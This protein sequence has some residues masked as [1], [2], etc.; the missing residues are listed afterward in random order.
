VSDATETTT[1]AAESHRER[2]LEA[3][4]AATKLRRA[5]ALVA[6]VD[7]VRARGEP[8]APHAA[9]LRELADLQERLDG[10]LADANQLQKEITAAVV[11]GMFYYLLTL[12]ILIS[13]SGFLIISYPEM[14]IYFIIA[15]GVLFVGFLAFYLLRM[16]HFRRTTGR[17]QE[18]LREVAESSADL[19]ETIGEREAALR[20]NGLPLETDSYVEYRSLLGLLESKDGEGLSEA[21]GLA[22]LE[23]EAARA[24]E[25]L[26]LSAPSTR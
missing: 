12:A 15:M 20:A 6:A 2:E 7:E 11:P 22:A 5:R 19:L 9:R 8:V 26:R 10:R 13:L 17:L 3:G 23:A 25:A 21:V 18:R 16:Q 14:R 1:A 4:R 24:E